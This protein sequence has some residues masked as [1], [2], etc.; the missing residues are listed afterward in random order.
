MRKKIL[1]GLFL[2]FSTLAFSQTD[3]LSITFDNTDL[4]AALLEIEKKTSHS[5]FYDENWFAEPENSK[6][7]SGNYKDKKT[8]FILEDI[9]KGTEI[10]FFVYGR[11]IILTNNNYIY[12]ELPPGFFGEDS[13]KGEES[14]Q[15]PVF[16]QEFAKVPQ[17][18]EEAKGEELLFIG[19]E[20]KQKNETTF[21]LSGY[22]R[23]EK[24]G[25]PISSVLVKTEDG[26]ITDVT[27]LDGFY[28]L[29]LPL[30]AN[31]IQAQSLGFATSTKQVMMYSDGT[32]DFTLAESINQLGEIVIYGDRGENIR[33]VVTGVTS[34]EPEKMKVVPMVLGVRDVVK[35][36]LLMPG[37]KTTG[38]GA[39]GFNVRGGK[40][41][42]NLILLDDAVIYNPFHFFG[43][44]SAVNPYAIGSV[45][46]Y[47]G[48]IPAEYGGRLSS[49][50][51]IQTKTPN[52]NKFS[53]EGGIGPVNGNLM[54]SIPIVKE[55]AALSVGGRY[56]YADWILRSLD[57]ASLKDSKA[58]FFDVNLKYAH[59]LDDRNR[60]EA[61]VYYS[62]DKFNLTPDSLQGYNNTLVSLRWEHKFNNKHRGDLQISNSNYGFDLEYRPDN[63][64][65][66]DYGFELNETKA[67]LRMNYE[68]SPKHTFTYGI[69][70]KLYQIDPGTYQPIHPASL[71]DPMNLDKEKALESAVFLSDAFE[72]SDKLL[73][74]A[75]IR[76][77]HFI[78]LGK[79]T[80]RIYDPTQPKSGASVVETRQYDENESIESYG[81]IEW[82]LS[83]RYLLTEDFSVKAGYSTANQYIH[84]LSTNTTQS[85]LDTWKLS[86][87][88]IEPQSS[89][90]FSLG[91][92]KNFKDN[93]YELSLE[94]YYKNLDNLVD[95]KTG[96]DLFMDE[97]LETSILQGEGKAYGIEFL[98]KKNH[99]KLNGW[100]AYTYSRS[101]LKLDGMF[102]EETVNNGD[103][104]P[105][106]FDKP[107]DLSLVLNY[108]LTTRYSFSANFIYQTG[109]PVTFP[110]G[111]YHYAGAQYT[112]YSDRNQYRIPDYYRLD[113]GFNIE[114]NH[115]KNK[116][117]HSF[118]NISVYNVLGRN[119]PYSV[120]FV[121][122]EGQ[123][124][125]Y[126]TSIFS[127]P[128]PT[129]TYNFK[130]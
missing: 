76:Y 96:A 95:Y 18:G 124:K 57:E 101:F 106:N 41:D 39:A 88:N 20:A 13:L 63:P 84:L 6:K 32:Y 19:K 112:L 64:N 83:A 121:T 49:V 28:V 3:N 71:L 117:A 51:D 89:Q 61:T 46:I 35:S 1:S 33:S 114:G 55:K 10:N 60:L 81:D 45:D 104:F 108:K 105:T 119:N 52:M 21:Q 97:H 82:R 87:L 42:Q 44:F 16:Y 98:A 12:D 73:V 109:R 118:I 37:V 107:H 38:E 59:I 80:Q 85:P 129:I 68:Y 43:F 70:G 130:F 110:V 115:K 92:F 125:G 91:F 78:A 69:E 100:L 102:N 126:K 47:K 22:V 56:A 8:A 26:Q 9:L 17:Q 58:S 90:Q 29:N 113:I 128:I 36:A 2:I 127:V 74:D 25:Q 120:Y 94:G 122:D 54:L 66:F 99:G 75:G 65:S 40:T 15:K 24:T 103:Y 93:Q 116:L 34:I 11:K 48:N 30:G 86:D 79:G 7:V 31:I 14:P 23:N 123:I 67:K 72:I 53:G 5:F 77:S 50:F 4:K 111:T 62:Q 27:D